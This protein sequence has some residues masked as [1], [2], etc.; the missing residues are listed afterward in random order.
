MF[1]QTKFTILKNFFLLTLHTWRIYIIYSDHFLADRYKAFCSKPGHYDSF[2]ERKVNCLKGLPWWLSGKESAWQCRRHGFNPWVGKM[3]W[4]RK[5]Q[6]T[7]VFFPG[8]SHGQKS[9]ASYSPWGHKIVGYSPMTKQ[10]ATTTN[11][12]EEIKFFVCF[13]YCRVG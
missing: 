11:C 7:P 2:Q 12:L 4:R 5:W 13:I 1:T 9:L 3:S 6:P 10:Q 8:K